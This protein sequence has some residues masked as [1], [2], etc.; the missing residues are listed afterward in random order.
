MLLLPWFFPLFVRDELPVYLIDDAWFFGGFVF[1][2]IISI[3]SIF[4]YKNRQQQV[5]SGR[6][7]V[8]LNF[9]LFGFLMYYFFSSMNS[10]ADS[11]GTA[12]FLPIATVIFISLANRAIMKDEALV[13]SADRFR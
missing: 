13:R 8:L 10:D 2:G 9:V 3:F 12:A 4:R 11:I 5:V 7:N 1:S 6:I